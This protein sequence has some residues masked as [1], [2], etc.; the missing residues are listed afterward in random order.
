MDRQIRTKTDCQ[1]TQEAF[2]RLLAWLDRDR[3]R[4]GEKYEQIRSRLIK[5]FTRRGC[6]VAEELTDETIDRVSR[7][8]IEIAD[9]YVGDRALYF[10]GVATNVHLE[11]VKQ[12]KAKPL[13]QPDAP[14]VLERNY[15]CL[16]R[17]LEQLGSQHRNLVIEYYRSEKRAKIDHR[18]MLAGQQGISVNTLRI[19]RAQDQG[20]AARMRF[21]VYRA[22][23]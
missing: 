6:S 20:H 7:K 13:P 9:S 10:Y 14:E 15:I 2:D 16:E 12:P 17:C 5:I 3:E 23:R 21:P 8:V 4:A 1:L 18:R 22:E 11:Y 19:A